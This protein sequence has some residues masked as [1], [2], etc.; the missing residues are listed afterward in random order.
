MQGI[1]LV[2]GMRLSFT[3]LFLA[4]IASCKTPNPASTTKTEK[5]DMK[6]QDFTSDQG[7]FTLKLPPNWA[8]TEEVDGTYVFEDTTDWTGTFRI[9]PF[10]YKNKQGNSVST[11][12]F[13]D[14]EYAKNTPLSPKRHSINF[15]DTVSYKQRVEQDSEN[16][17]I[18]N[19]LMG[20]S[21]I[22]LICTFT[23]DA[24][25]E[26]TEEGKKELDKAEK[27]IY[28]IKTQ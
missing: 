7:W 8:Q 6:Y 15:F 27:I 28:S 23:I 13:L 11:D 20:K 1:S 19:W 25:N 10:K 5:A 9:K 21:G 3:I 12:D 16:F 18:Y 17:T 4:V 14:E 22:V 26:N 2:N 24:A